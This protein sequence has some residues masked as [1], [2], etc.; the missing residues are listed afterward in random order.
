[1]LLGMTLGERKKETERERERE[2][3]SS[4]MRFTADS[5]AFL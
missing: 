3:F 1:M 5:F 4:C 2:N